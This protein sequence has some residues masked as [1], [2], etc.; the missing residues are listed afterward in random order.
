MGD[1]EMKFYFK[2]LDGQEGWIEGFCT[3]ELQIKRISY[4][5]KM[6]ESYKCGEITKE[7]LTEKLLKHEQKLEKR[8][9]YT[10]G[11]VITNL[12]ELIV[13]EWVYFYNKLTHKKWFGNWQFNFILYNINRRL[14]YKAIKKENR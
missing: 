10:K 3:E 8:R 4:K 13:C 5:E 7:E 14:F 1:N 12:N 2:S 6:V 9:K 11:E